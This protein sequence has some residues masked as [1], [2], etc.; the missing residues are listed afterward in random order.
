MDTS[1]TFTT[2]CTVAF[3]LRKHWV[4]T[5]GDFYFSL[6]KKDKCVKL[7]TK[8][9][10]TRV[11]KVWLPR[12]DQMFDMLAERYKVAGKPAYAVN[13]FHQYLLAYSPELNASVE[14]LLLQF[15]MHEIFDLRYNTDQWIAAPPKI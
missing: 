11:N 5:P 6:Y 13:K 4:A 1:P 15:V 14:Q 2:M 8:C 10:E 9:K 7:I 12:V 3:A